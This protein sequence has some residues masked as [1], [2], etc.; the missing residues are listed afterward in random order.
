MRLKNI[1]LYLLSGIATQ[2]CYADATKLS[3]EDRKNLEKPSQF[4]EFILPAIC[5]PQS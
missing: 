2:I 1:G 5:H 4:H 3:T